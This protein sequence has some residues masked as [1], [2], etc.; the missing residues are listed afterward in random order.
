MNIIHNKKLETE[1]KS[2]NKKKKQPT[3]Y[4]EEMQVSCCLKNILYFEFMCM[5]NVQHW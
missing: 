4:T 3:K 2:K 5:F 1:L